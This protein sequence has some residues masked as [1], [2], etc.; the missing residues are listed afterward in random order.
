M[1]ALSKR[2]LGAVWKPAALSL[3]LSATNLHSPGRKSKGFTKPAGVVSFTN[4]H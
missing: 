3:I 2:D 4:R 1:Q